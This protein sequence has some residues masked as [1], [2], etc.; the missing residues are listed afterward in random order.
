MQLFCD[1]AKAAEIALIDHRLQ[2]LPRTVV[3]FNGAPTE[4]LSL[5][6]WSDALQEDIG[7]HLMLYDFDDVRGA[8][9][10]DARGHSARGNIEAV[11]RLVHDAA[12]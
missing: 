12:P 4:A 6:C 7:V 2:Y 9:K 8:L 10:P 1:D 11:R 5:H 3:G